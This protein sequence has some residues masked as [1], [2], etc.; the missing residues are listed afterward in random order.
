MPSWNLTNG[1]PLHLSLA[2]DA[3]FGGADYLNDHNWELE[4]G[5]GQPA[6]LSL[7]TTF[8]LRAR[9]MRIFP[10]FNE[11]R[12]TVTDPAT[13]VA[14][15]SLRAFYPNLLILQ[16]SPFQNLEVTAEFWVP[17]SQTLA[18]RYTLINR[19]PASRKIRLDVSAALVPLDGS[20]F[21]ATQI[22]M[23]NVLAASTGGLAPLLFMS[24]GPASVTGAS[25]SLTVT[26]DLAPGA[27]RQITWTEA[28][29][30]TAEA[31]F[32]LARR[33]ASRPFDAER[34]RIELTSQSET[35][36]IQTGDPDWD[37]AFAFTQKAALSLFFPASEHLPNASFVTSRRPDSGFSRTRD[38][39]DYPLGWAGQSPLDAYYLSGLLPGAPSLA[40]G[41][42]K[43]FLASQAEDGVIDMRPG[44]KGQRTKMLA[45][46]ILASTAWH[47]YLT[48]G[49]EKFLAESFPKLLSFFWNWF[50]LAHDRDAD[51]LP[52]W[53]HLLQTGWEDNPLFDVW[54]PSAQSVDVTTVINPG[55]Y[56]LLA[57][58]AGCLILM[59]DKLGRAGEVELVRVQAELLEKS[60]ADSWDE[61]AALY[62][63]RD[64]NTRL[65]LP[66][67]ILATAN[68]KEPIKPKLEF[69]SP[70]RLLIQIQ[71]ANPAAKRPEVRISEY[72]SKT[73]V[74]IITPEQFTWRSG[75]LVATSRRVYERL[76]L[77]SAKGLKEEDVVI[78]KTVDLT[79][80]DHTLFLPLW[81]ALPET[82]RAQTLLRALTDADRFARPFGIPA[83]ASSSAPFDTLRASPEADSVSRSVH[84]PWNNL[85]GEGLLGYGFKDEAARLVEKLMSAVIQN[86][87]NG[88]AFYQSY[89][90]D[91]GA[92][93]GERNALAGLAPLGLFLQTLGVTILSGTSV[94]LEGKNPFAWPITLRYRGMTITR[95]LESTE[96]S[97][98][99][100]KS[101]T[102]TD[103]AACVVS[104]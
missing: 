39:N 49:D 101:V 28:A 24:G 45:A 67:K 69:Y 103:N 95:G 44:L 74:E 54:H 104:A 35:V 51:G 80:Q 73:P 4:L 31:S 48:N 96:V 75:G 38:G 92:G 34:A 61:H 18:G 56:A 57:R 26:L 90:A 43:N 36:E 93:L 66:G 71:T 60:V 41:L 87:K 13:F 84:L 8:G 59:A 33:T 22:Q 97:F 88:R 27:S 29:L 32:E 30:E 65:S 9:S 83:V 15:P 20:P 19:A 2:A 89:H 42:L 91:N 68:G 52:E 85:I 99:N 10:S 46:P 3:R 37:A 6:A 86:L 21:A 82:D 72:V 40:H 17:S 81:A 70:V 14:P 94:R 25:P 58:E 23:V 77:V 79:A 16:F 5:A 62:R 76:G 11:G 64:L 53:D 55:L 102:V 12:K 98:L 7:H 47:I 50:A 78:V 63:Y 1:D 100:G